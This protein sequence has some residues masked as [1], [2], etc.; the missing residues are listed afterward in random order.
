MMTGRQKGKHGTWENI[1]DQQKPGIEKEIKADYSSYP[2]H[3]HFD[4]MSH[5]SSSLIYS[6]FI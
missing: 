6:N 5:E 4:F 2:F 3:F 1:N